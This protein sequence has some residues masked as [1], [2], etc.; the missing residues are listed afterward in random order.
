M[1]LLIFLQHKY[2]HVSWERLASGMGIVN[3]FDFLRTSAD[4]NLDPEFEALLL[5]GDVAANLSKA[6]AHGEKIA[7]ETMELFI[8]YLAIE[9]ANMALKFK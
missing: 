3:I 2:G 8:R 7:V 4:Y 5:T 6:A 1:N 9:S